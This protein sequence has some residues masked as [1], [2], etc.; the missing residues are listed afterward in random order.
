[1]ASILLAAAPPSFD[2]H[3]HGDPVNTAMPHVGQEETNGRQVTASASG[4]L[5]SVTVHRG[6]GVLLPASP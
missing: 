6:V 1:M 4:W 2:T 5:V 3:S